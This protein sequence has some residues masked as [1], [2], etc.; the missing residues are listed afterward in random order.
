[1]HVLIPMAGHSRRFKTAGYE[2]PKALLPVGEAPMIQRVVDMFAPSDHFHFIVNEE[3]VRESPRLIE[4]LRAT[5]ARTSV[6]VIPA[7]EHGPAYSARQ[8]SGI[9]DDAEIIISY[10]DFMVQ[11]DYGRFLRHVHG[12]DGAVASFRGFHPASFGDTYY[13][14]MRTDGDR[15]LELR[16]KQSF[17]D[18]R[19]REH[20]SV[21][22]YYFRSWDLFRRYADRLLDRGTRPLPEAYVSLLY[23]DMVRDRLDVT[24]Y[25]VDRF[26]CLGTPSD[27]EQ[28]LFWW[29]YFTHG[30]GLSSAPARDVT[31]VNLVP[32]AGQGN[33]FR[34]YGYRVAKPLIQ[35][36][37]KPMVVHAA[38]SMPE[39]DQFIFLARTNDLRRHP[40]EASLRAFLPD[41]T[42]LPVKENTSGQA[43]TCLLAER[44][45]PANAELM[46]ASCDYEQRYDPAAWRRILDDPRIDGAVWTWRAD[47]HFLKNPEAFAYCRTG[48]DGATIIEISEK[49]TISDRPGRDPLAIGTFWYR[50][51]GDFLHGAR[52]MIARG[53]TVNGEHYVGTSINELI[54][55]GARFVIFEVEQW[56]SFGDPFE[57]KVLEFWESYFADTLSTEH[58]RRVEA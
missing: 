5:A 11:W 20:A 35:V 26:V 55:E 27:Y 24:V 47:G 14:Y 43:A 1:M 12:F 25:E 13:A 19:T 4:Q 9:E 46:I 15:M 51:A 8:V 2:G 53:K 41:C 45:L 38:A 10:C 56:I 44:A 37:G 18:D 17:T 36:R 42:V 34:R 7:H 57:L 40:I 39:A 23:N 49:R 29:R 33:R 30:Q 58:S 54:E 52:K 3:Q 21:G 28:Y 6:T 31:R 50:R 48:E 32:M 16:E 22:L